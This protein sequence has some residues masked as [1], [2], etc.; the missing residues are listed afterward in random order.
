M[1]S[2]GADQK[3]GLAIQY[4]TDPAAIYRDSFR[5]IGERADLTA[6][7][8]QES[9]I[10]A[11]VIHASAD[12]TL[13]E[14]LVF[15]P[16]AV[17]MALKVL[18]HSGH[19]VVDARMV[20][21]GLNRDRLSRLGIRVWCGIDQPEVGVLA[22]RQGITRSMAAMDWA[23]AQAPPGC[24]VVIGNA[25]TALFRLLQ[26]IEAGWWQPAVVV[27]LPVGLVGAAESKAQLMAQTRVPAMSN[28]GSRG[29]SAAA[30]A[31]VNAL[32]RMV[33]GEPQ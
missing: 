31:A 11:R 22:Q 12:F 29:G 33:L 1:E 23:M 17:P 20:E 16:A 15:H 19:L 24:L 7:S 28:R 8:P 18:N 2:T 10:A 13:G 21:A 27:G 14:S 9:Q 25:P 6:F 30:A 32:I 26:G 5:Q 4:V 3:G